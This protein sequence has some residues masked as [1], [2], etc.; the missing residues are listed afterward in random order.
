MILFSAIKISKS[1]QLRLLDLESCILESNID[2]YLFKI[3]LSSINFNKICNKIKLISSYIIVT[4]SKNSFSFSFSEHEAT[5][6]ITWK[7]FNN[8]VKQGKNILKTTNPLECISL[9]YVKD[10]IIKK[11]Y[12]L[13]YLDEFTNAIK[14]NPIINIYCDDQNPMLLEYTIGCKGYFRIYIASSLD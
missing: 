10:I 3:S 5:G 7:S 11:K 14:I 9:E 12:L 13:K 8:N 1:F 6:E 4:C 2:G